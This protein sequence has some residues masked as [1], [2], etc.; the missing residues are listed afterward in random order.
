[1]WVYA[2][3]ETHRIV[4]LKSVH[5]SYVSYAS[6]KTTNIGKKF[7]RAPYAPI[8]AHY[9]DEDVVKLLLLYNDG[10]KFKFRRK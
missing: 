3:V 7:I 6:I 1:M 2:F 10:K 5:L 8:V 9:A 4:H